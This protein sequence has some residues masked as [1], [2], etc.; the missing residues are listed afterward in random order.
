MFLNPSSLV[1]FLVIANLLTCINARSP[2]PPSCPPSTDMAPLAAAEA[3]SWESLQANADVNAALAPPEGKTLEDDLATAL[4]LVW[5]VTLRTI[6][7]SAYKTPSSEVHDVG[8]F[9][10]G[11]P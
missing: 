5:G 9:S 11:H 8:H 6:Q 3:T 10:V 2:T 7:M 1:C 4:N